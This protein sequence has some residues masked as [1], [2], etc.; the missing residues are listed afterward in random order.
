[1]KYRDLNGFECR[2]SFEKGKS[3]IKSRHVIV[4]AQYEGKWLLTDHPVRGLEFPGGKRE[5]G[6]TLEEAAVRETYEETGGVLKSLKWVGEYKVMAERPFVKTAFLAIVER[7]E[8]IPLAETRGAVLVKEL[9][10]NDRYSFLM[11]DEGMKEL[12]RI[13]VFEHKKARQEP[14]SS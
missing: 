3:C 4:L 8:K 9:D 11:K 2:L 6:E 7:L 13:A 12:I 1:M 10:F 14:G 5:R